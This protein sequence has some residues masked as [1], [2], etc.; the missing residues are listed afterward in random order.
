[1]SRSTLNGAAVLVPEVAAP[2]KV[3]WGNSIL[4]QVIKKLSSALKGGPISLE[5]SVSRGR[6]TLENK[7]KG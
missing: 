1:M 7:G 4:K 2:F 6:V 3:E 5:D